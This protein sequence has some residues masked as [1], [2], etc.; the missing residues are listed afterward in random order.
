M[1][2]LTFYFLK[3]IWSSFILILKFSGLGCKTIFTKSIVWV[4]KNDSQDDAL[5]ITKPVLTNTVAMSG[6]ERKHCLLN[7]DNDLVV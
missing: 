4:A 7:I 3:K 5:I 1:V 6:E 2:I